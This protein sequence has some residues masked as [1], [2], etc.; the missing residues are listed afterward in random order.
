M[1]KLLFISGKDVIKS[2]S[3]IDAIEQMKAAFASLSSKETVVPQRTHLNTIDE[4][5]TTLLMPSYNPN[6]EKIAVKILNTF[7]DNSLKNIS[8]SHAIVTLYNG[9]TGEP[10]AIID[11]E[12]LTQIR[13]GAAS[14]LA[15]EL[16]ARENS[17]TVAIFGP[18]HQGRTQLEAVCSIRNITTAFVFGKH[19]HE[20]EKFAVE[21]SDKLNINFEVCVDLGSLKNADIICTATPSTSPLFSDNQIKDGVHINAVGSYKPQMIEVPHETIARAKVIVDSRESCLHEAGDI[22]QAIEKKNFSPYK[23]WGELGEVVL[24][25]IPARESES[26]ITFFKSVGNAVQDLF[27]AVKIYENCKKLGIGVEVEL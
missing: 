18:G 22:I 9:T 4:S 19:L 12:T 25:K 11:G 3:M 23:I 15:T 13:T 2:F 24:K 27:S 1:S 20:S 5:G 17:T 14:G 10:L 21:M 8:P 7:R 6:L 16:L 26:E